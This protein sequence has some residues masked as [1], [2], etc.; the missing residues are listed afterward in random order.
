MLNAVANEHLFLSRCQASVDLWTSQQR[1][2]MERHSAPSARAARCGGQGY[3]PIDGY[4]AFLQQRRCQ[5]AEAS[6]SFV[7]SEMAAHFWH[8][9][10]HRA[11]VRCAVAVRGS[12]LPRQRGSCLCGSHANHCAVVQRFH[13]TG[14]RCRFILYERAFAEEVRDCAHQIDASHQHRNENSLERIQN[15]PV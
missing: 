5:V 14:S 1:S 10:S 15:S 13:R 12:S 4:K 3:L 11:L 2:R 6:I 8:T 7:V 9:I